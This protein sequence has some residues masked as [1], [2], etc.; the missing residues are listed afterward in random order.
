MTTLLLA[1]CLQ[2]AQSEFGFD[3][4]DRVRKER[5]NENV[6]LSPA[7]VYFALAMTYNGS[8]GST[9]EAMAKV[10]RSDKLTMEDF[11]KDVAALLKALADVD[12]RVKLA[13][14]NSLWV[15]KDMKFQEGFLK[16]VKETYRAEAT[17]LDFGDPKSTARLNDWVKTNT[18]G[19]IEKIVDEIDPEMIAYLVN[20]VYFKGDWTVEFDK[21]L[22]RD[23]NFTKLDGS[24]SK[25]PMM[26]RKGDFEVLQ[27]DAFDAVRLPYGK[28]GRMKMYVFVPKDF[29]KFHASFDFETWTGKFRKCEADVTIPRFK[30]EFEIELKKVL[31]S[32]GMADAFEDSADFSQ[33]FVGQ[34]A[35]I[36]R[37]IH[38]TYVDVNEEGTE[39]AAVT[40]VEMRPTSA[41]QEVHIRADR[42]FVIVLRDDTTKTNLFI[43]AIV[44]P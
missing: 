6:F 18:G 15:R 39:A 31:G 42:P 27:N 29:E 2:E 3:L 30:V 10:L 43:G 22:T 9:R 33:M 25:K 16:R 38:K 24:K 23:Q 35:A 11:N 34:S 21:K 8:G 26:Y 17:S 36:N 44:N 41:V 14:A 20:A 19:R 12:P 1:F 7:S 4:Y 40:A 13:I 32:M 5:K 37:V 28:N